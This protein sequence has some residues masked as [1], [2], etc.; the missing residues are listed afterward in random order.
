MKAEVD[1]SKDPVAYW[2]VPN[3]QVTFDK[4]TSIIPSVPAADKNTGR[5]NRINMTS[6]EGCLGPEDKGKVFEKCPDVLSCLE[7]KGIA[8]REECAFFSP[9]RNNHDSHPVR[10]AVGE[11]VK[12]AGTGPQGL[13]HADAVASHPWTGPAAAGDPDQCL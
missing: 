13:G 9:T 12:A 5:K 7:C 2:G 6:D 8:R 4:V 10:S 3:I 11:P 1:I